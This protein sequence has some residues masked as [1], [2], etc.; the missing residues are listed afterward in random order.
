MKKLIPVAA[1][2]IAA[3]VAGYSSK[4]VYEDYRSDKSAIVFNNCSEWPELYKSLDSEFR[5]FCKN[6]IN[7]SADTQL[8]CWGFHFELGA[9]DKS[10]TLVR[11]LVYEN[12]HPA[13]GNRAVAVR[14]I[15]FNFRKKGKEYKIIK[16]N[17]LEDE[18]ITESS[19]PLNGFDYNQ[20]GKHWE[21]K[22]HEKRNYPIKYDKTLDKWH[23]AK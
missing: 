2:L 21:M 13:V 5:K 10:A 3:G 19:V 20:Y 7:D 12:L 9:F 4:G 18:I 8:S 15:K 16:A 11:E 1:A 17:L 23:V 22:Q 6:Y 14:R